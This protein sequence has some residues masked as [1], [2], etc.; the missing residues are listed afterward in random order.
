MLTSLKEQEEVH[1]FLLGAGPSSTSSRP[2]DE[3]ESLD[4]VDIGG[5]Y[6]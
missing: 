4:N 5:E 2:V 6:D 1:S 3:T